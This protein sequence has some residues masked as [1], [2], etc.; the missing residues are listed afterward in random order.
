MHYNCIQL[1]L[2]TIKHTPCGN[3]T[4][5]SLPLLV[6]YINY[7]I[8]IKYINSI[9]LFSKFKPNVNNVMDFLFAAFKL[10]LIGKKRELQ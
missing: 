8:Y 4:V 1:W 3:S 7:T 2:K 10:L 6:K 9:N 5:F